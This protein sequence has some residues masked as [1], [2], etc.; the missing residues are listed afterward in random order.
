MTKPFSPRELVARVRAV[1]RRTAGPP[2]RR[3]PAARVGPVHARPGP[4]AGHRRR[5]RRCSSPPTEFDLLAHLMARPGRVF[6]REEL[7]A[8]VWGYAAHAGTRTVDVHVAQ[9]R[10]K[11][12]AGRRDPHRPR[13]RVRRRCLTAGTRVAD[14]AAAG[15]RRRPPAAPAATRPYAH[16]PRGAGHLRGGAGRRCWSPRSSRCR[17]RSAARSSATRRRSPT[18]AGSPPSVLRTRLDRRR[19]ADEERLIQQLRD[20]GHR[21]VPDPAR[22]GRPGRACRAGWCTRIAAGRNVVSRAAGRRRAG[23]WSRGG[24]LP[25]GNGRGADPGRRA[26]GRGAPGAAQPLAAAAGRAR[27]RGGGRAAAGPPAGPAD[28]QRG[29]RRRPA[30]RRRPRGPAAG[31]AARRGRRPGATRSTS[32][33]RRW[34]PARAGS[35]SSCSPSRTSCAPR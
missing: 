34:P 18:Q 5:R 1:L 4:A 27:R 24:P 3:G 29:H 21:R 30:A 20:A 28:P 22:R 35:A 26:T 10:A 2:G 19:S 12:G 16:R 17:W 14:H 7:L 23:R 33:P 15:G 32:W 8:G 11:L 9:V 25:G 31:R 6:T 13:R